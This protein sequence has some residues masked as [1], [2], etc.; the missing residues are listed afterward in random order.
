MITFELVEHE[1]GN[2]VRMIIDG[3]EYAVPCDESN[4]DYQRYLAWLE[5]PETALL[6]PIVAE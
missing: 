4:S 2:W 6:T 1:R 5:N 3:Q